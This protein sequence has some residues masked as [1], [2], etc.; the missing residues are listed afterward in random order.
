MANPPP[1]V[2]QTICQPETT[3][4]DSL[5]LSPVPLSSRI[6]PSGGARLAGTDGEALAAGAAEGLDSCVAEGDGDTAGA[7]PESRATLPSHDPIPHPTI[8]ATTR[9]ATRTD[10]RPILVTVP[11]SD[12]NSYLV[13][14]YASQVGGTVIVG[15][16]AVDPSTVWIRT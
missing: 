12:T 10:R 13:L 1:S 2:C 5:C 3:V 7:D 14:K 6:V 8:A 16:I 9:T 11:W 15:D 4:N